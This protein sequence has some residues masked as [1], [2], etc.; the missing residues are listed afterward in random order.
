MGHGRGASWD[1]VGGNKGPFPGKQEAKPS[2][3][4]FR[5]KLRHPAHQQPPRPPC[6]PPRQFGAVPVAWRNSTRF[7][8][9]QEAL[10]FAAGGATA[11]LALWLVARARPTPT[12][13]S[14]PPASGPEP[15]IELGK[16]AR[17]DGQRDLLQALGEELATLASGIE[18]RA[19]HLIEAAPE[20]RLLPAAAEDLDRAVRR[21]RRMHRK[22]AAFCGNE[23]TS[24]G[25]VELA[26]ALPRVTEAVQELH[27]GIE[28][29]FHP[30]TTLPPIAVAEATLVDLFAFLTAAM[31]RTEPG[32][33]R[34]NLIAEQSLSTV[35]E[36]AFELTLEWISEPTPAAQKPQRATMDFDAC[37]NLVRSQGGT[38][39][40]T[41]LPGKL[42]Q[43][44]LTLPASERAPIA[45]P[46]TI[47]P[48]TDG[49]GG[50]LLLEPDPAIRAMVARELKTA[51][52]SVFACADSNS[53]RAFLENSP[54]RFEL[55][56]V[57]HA[58]RL[59]AEEPLARSLRAVAPEL[60]VLVL[61]S[62]TRG[63]LSP[64]T[65]HTLPKPFG[66]PELRE[67]LALTLARR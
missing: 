31:L 67:A 21:L 43:A 5:Q 20:R 18:G 44:L 7:L 38:I 27:L 46:P 26:T 37:A 61:D 33:T 32:A 60:R 65:Y 57:D 3:T 66:V 39:E 17:S 56:V 62:A 47:P 48:P 13:A 41:H 55:L 50:A 12:P 45:N 9:V 29:H 11:F 52:R 35:R 54:Q 63:T 58:H 6:A 53:A 49:F 19:H 15:A 24:H 59:T 28:L 10:W 34:L 64:L 51:G 16:Q 30:P 25:Q 14:P 22:V 8:S 40:F 1:W 4:E 42:V 36:V 2:V 23:P